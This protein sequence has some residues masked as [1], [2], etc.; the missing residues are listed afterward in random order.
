MI[1]RQRVINSL[2]H[3]P[4]DRAP[5]DLWVHPAVEQLH[6]DWLT[7]MNFRFPPDIERPPVNYPRGERA[8]GK[9]AEVGQS[10]DAWGCTWAVSEPAAAPVL[11]VHP[12]KEKAEIARYKPPMELLDPAKLQRAEPGR[13][14]STKFV[15]AGTETR[16]FERLQMLRGRE[17]ALADLARPTRDVRS[18]L[19]SLHEFSC[20]EMELWGAMDVDGVAFRDDWGSLDGL[21]LSAKTWRELFK[22]LYRQYC[23][24]LHSH[25]KFA[26]FRSEGNITEIFG[27]LVEIGV[28]AIHAQLGCMDLGP[29]AERFRGRVT[30]WGD[31]DRLKILP[32]GT[33]ADVRAAVRH[34]R[35]ALDFGRGGL[36]AQCEWA[37]DF[38]F[39]NIAAVFDEWLR[40][41]PA[42]GAK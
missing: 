24:I 9:P 25:D 1:S 10:T 23:E 34:V 15:L 2:N 16:P 22:P 5:R 13:T 20:K 33:S 30:F 26:F 29:L 31:V 8:K 21:L 14:L 17:A 19:A 32:Q 6:P 40:P 41:L 38:P 7:E 11:Q 35:D 27:D 18:L 39:H 12:L 42:H 4:V 36:I 28:D 3:Q 37:P